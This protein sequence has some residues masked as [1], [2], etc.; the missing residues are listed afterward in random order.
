MTPLY[1][2][3]TYVDAG[4]GDGVTLAKTI[5]LDV[6]WKVEINCLTNGVTIPAGFWSDKYK[7]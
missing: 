6:I 1:V 4:L 3:D 5:W 7:L 2:T